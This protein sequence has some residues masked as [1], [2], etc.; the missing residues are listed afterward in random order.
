MLYYD[1][2][3]FLLIKDSCMQKNVLLGN[4]L[5]KTKSLTRKKISSFNK[6]QN[7]LKLCFQF[8][9]KF[10][11]NVF[12]NKPNEMYILIDVILLNK[13]LQYQ[14]AQLHY[15]SVEHRRCGDH[16]YFCDGN[17][18]ALSPFHIHPGGSP[19]CHGSQLG[20][21]FLQN[22]TYIFCPQATRAKT[23]HDREDGK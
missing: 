20:H 11:R 3:L 14:A 5:T 18:L 15:R 9:Q 8:Q 22:F 13:E 16:F 6:I 17:C 23:C 2:F 12:V 1:I 19:L 4:I 10:R 7:L 21:L